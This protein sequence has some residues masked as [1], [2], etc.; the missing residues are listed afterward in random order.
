MFGNDSRVVVNSDPYSPIITIRTKKF[1]FSPEQLAGLNRI[2]PFA[3]VR[4]RYFSAEFSALKRALADGSSMAAALRRKDEAADAQLE[5]WKREDWR[6]IS[7]FDLSDVHEKGWVGVPRTK[8]EVWTTIKMHSDRVIASHRVTLLVKI[9][10]TIQS[11]QA[12]ISVLLPSWLW[13][14]ISTQRLWLSIEPCV[15]GAWKPRVPLVSHPMW[16][17]MT[18]SCDKLL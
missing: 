6:N 4:E 3:G 11:K 2:V 17:S 14:M 10:Q 9:L 18:P 7:K 15:R 16:F 8:R 12:A 5:D 13:M 1:K